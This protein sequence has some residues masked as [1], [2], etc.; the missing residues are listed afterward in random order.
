LGLIRNR[1]NHINDAKYDLNLHLAGCLYWNTLAAL[2]HRPEYEK[3]TGDSEVQL[4]SRIIQQM[5]RI[6]EM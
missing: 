5:A 6:L 1:L 3:L 2:D 4:L